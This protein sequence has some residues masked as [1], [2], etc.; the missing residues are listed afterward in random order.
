MKTAHTLIALPLTVV[1]LGLLGGGGCEQRAAQ[2]IVRTAPEVTISQALQR[3]VGDSFEFTGNTA[4]MEEVHVRARVSGYLKEVRFKDGEEVEAG[5]VLYQIDPDEYQAAV[6]RSEAEVARQEA[7]LKKSSADLARTQ[8]LLE[9]GVKSREEYDQDSASVAV[10]QAGLAA[11]KAT[12]RKA[13]LDLSYCNITAAISGRISKTNYTVGNLIH[14]SMTGSEVMTTIVRLDPIYIYFHMDERAILRYQ[15]VAKQLGQPM[16][17]ER[18]ED[19]KVP[20][21]AALA[22]EQGFPH[23]GMLN[24]ADNRLDPTT[25]TILVRAIFDNADRQLSPGLFVRVSIPFGMPR[26]ALLMSERAI[27]S[28]QGEKY[29]LVVDRDGPQKNVAQ[30]RAVKLG[31]LQGG[32][33]VVESGL[34]PEDWV[35]T[36]GVQNV[37]PGITVEPREGP[38]PLPANAT[39]DLAA[40]PAVSGTK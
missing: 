38:M 29:V 27:A 26:K 17:T 4:A 31:S 13:H 6:D 7:M 12:L 11:A 30:Y 1:L 33:R 3:E 21:C 20:V 19:W 32:L 25:G 9:K 23:K 24:F 2:K 36:N 40:P 16:R 15:E 5:E 8:I 35:I 14:A 10:A 37:R 34:K 22:N 18:V 39:P 28:D